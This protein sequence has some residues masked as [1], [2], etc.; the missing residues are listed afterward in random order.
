[1]LL[2][3]SGESW[4]LRLDLTLNSTHFLPS[5]LLEVMGRVP[6]GRFPVIHTPRR[7]MARHGLEIGVPTV[8]SLS[9]IYRII[10][11][12]YRDNSWSNNWYI[13]LFF[14]TTLSQLRRLYRDKYWSNCDGLTF[15]DLEGSNAIAVFVW[16]NWGK[17]RVRR[18]SRTTIVRN[19]FVGYVTYIFNFSRV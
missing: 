11:L 5:L 9:M 10:V 6:N 13:L 12:D 18:T 7:N 8:T 16:S 3:L 19:T 2:T 1:M 15:R 4:Q 17:H 14:V